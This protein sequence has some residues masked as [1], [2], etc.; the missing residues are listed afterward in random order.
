MAD[1]D[2]LRNEGLVKFGHT[3]GTAQK[4]QKEHGGELT[5]ETSTIF[6]V[7]DSKDSL[8]AETLLKAYLKQRGM[9]PRGRKEH[10]VRNIELIKELMEQAVRLAP[11]RAAR[12]LGNTP[13]TPVLTS[14]SPAWSVLL[15]VKLRMLDATRTIGEWMANSLNSPGIARALAKRGIVCVNC[16]HRAPEFRIE[17]L[18][19]D[20]EVYL[21]S[22]GF[23][24]EDLV[25]PDDGRAVCSLK[26]F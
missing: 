19:Q 17:Y 3:T 16:D 6:F 18:F 25:H 1:N 7:I 8:R 21:R 11:V 22:A 12:A 24:L 14:E 4:R 13:P 9:M 10:A 15:A 26:A 5:L 2:T 20:V 23:S